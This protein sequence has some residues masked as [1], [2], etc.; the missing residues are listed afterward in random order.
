MAFGKKKLK[1]S[2]A[3]R[4]VLTFVLLIGII[5]AAGYVVY[6]IQLSQYV[7]EINTMKYSLNRI[8]LMGNERL[9]AGTVLKPELFYED[10]I[11]AST[12]QDQYV[13]SEDY[14]KVLLVDLEQGIPLMKAM[15]HE[16]IISKDLREE[17]LNML[18]LPSNLRKDNYIDVRIGFPSGEDYIVLSKKKVRDI[19]LATNTFWLWVDEKEILTLSSAIVDAYLH[20]GAK[21]YTVTYVAPSIQDKAILN[22]PV[23]LDVLKVIIS[24]PNIIQE[25]KESL[26]QEARLQLEERLAKV[27]VEAGYSV[28]S[29]VK[30]EATNRENKINK[31]QETLSH[32]TTTI[33]DV[34]PE[35][36]VSGE[37]PNEIKEED[38]NGSFY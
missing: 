22:Y 9:P 30:E 16:E 11:S 34:T 21:L 6:K 33:N 5:G 3:V 20:K 4:T 25:A 28:E 12:L 2:K 17:E 15:V 38:I 14:G 8:V 27:S 13:T 37:E 10:E 35:G 23:N 36:S 24:N 32:E 1:M 7:T 29:G 31:E 18:L 19:Q 26:T